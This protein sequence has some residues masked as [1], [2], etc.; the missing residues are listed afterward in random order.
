MKTPL[1][2]TMRCEGCVGGMGWKSWGAGGEDIWKVKTSGRQSHRRKH[3]EGEAVEFWS[4][5]RVFGCLE[6][7][8][9]GE[10]EGLVS[11]VSRIINIPQLKLSTFPGGGR[12]SDAEEAAERT[13]IRPRGPARLSQRLGKGIVGARARSWRGG[14]GS[15]HSFVPSLPGAAPRGAD[16]A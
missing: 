3:L 14:G 2:Q 1:I 8:N 6:R 15:S 9:E 12:N 13:R 16:D 5:L 7:G 10:A 11:S 4:L